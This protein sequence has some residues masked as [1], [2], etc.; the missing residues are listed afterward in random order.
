M[1][2]VSA[3]KCSS[4]SSLR[5]FY[6]FSGFVKKSS[7]E[8]TWHYLIGEAKLVPTVSLPFLFTSQFSSNHIVLQGKTSKTLVHQN[9]FGVYTTLLLERKHLFRDKKYLFYHNHRDNCFQ[10]G[11][12]CF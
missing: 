7:N 6:E 3:A 10:F 2:E 11:N 5:H 9:D 4:P 12:K 1:K 8:A